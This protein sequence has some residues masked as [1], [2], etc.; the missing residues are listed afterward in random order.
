MVD[1]GQDAQERFLHPVQV[2]EGEIGMIE[3][4]VAK[5]VFEQGLKEVAELLSAADYQKYLEEEA[6]G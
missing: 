6:E 4:A 2:A 5:T 3:L 1:V